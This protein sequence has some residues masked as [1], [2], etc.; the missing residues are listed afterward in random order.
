M[1]AKFA[2]ACWQ[3]SNSD[4]TAQISELDL[5]QKRTRAMQKRMSALS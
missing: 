1:S 3:R 5:Q 4:L 2:V